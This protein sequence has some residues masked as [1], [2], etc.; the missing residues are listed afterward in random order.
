MVI[1]DL[2]SKINS[3]VDEFDQELITFRRDLHA[4]PELSF[5]EHRTTDRLIDRLLA[6]GLAPRRLPSGSVSIPRG[7]PK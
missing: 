4:H 1:D 7:S 2:G 6:A 5:E 3:L